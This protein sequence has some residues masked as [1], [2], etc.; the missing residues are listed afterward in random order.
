MKNLY[1]LTQNDVCLRHITNI[2]IGIHNKRSRRYGYEQTY[3]ENGKIMCKSWYNKGSLDNLKNQIF[4]MFD[5]TSKCKD[6][7]WF[8]RYN[9]NLSDSNH[10]LYFYAKNYIKRKDID[11]L[12]KLHRDSG[13]A[14]IIYHRNGKIGNKMWYSNGKLLH[15]Y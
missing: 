14:Q 6:A 10:S 5:M 7:S 13:P 8:G 12:G 9:A 1:F 3:Y 4:T 11:L 15:F 2:V